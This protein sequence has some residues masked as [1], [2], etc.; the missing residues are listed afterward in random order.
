MQATDKF[1]CKQAYLCPWCHGRRVSHLYRS[2]RQ[3]FVQQ[4]PFRW[5]M[6]IRIELSIDDFDADSVRL[7]NQFMSTRPTTPIA[8]ANAR[9]MRV[10]IHYVHD[11]IKEQLR[12]KIARLRLERGTCGLHPRSLATREPVTRVAAPSAAPSALVVRRDYRCYFVFKVHRL[13]SSETE[14]AKHPL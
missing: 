12:D 1:V 10:P 6:Q 5:L 8:G 7:W 4:I 13:L 3:R 2:R 9:W 14:T 11:E